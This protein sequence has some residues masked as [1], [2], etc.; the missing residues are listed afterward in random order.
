M[1][2]NPKCGGCH[3][4]RKATKTS[5]APQSLVRPHSLVPPTAAYTNSCHP[6]QRTQTW[7]S[8]VNAR[9]HIHHM[10]AYTMLYMH[11]STRTPEREG[12]GGGG[13]PPDPPPPPK[14]N[15]VPLGSGR[16]Y[17]PAPRQVGLPLTLYCLQTPIPACR[18]AWAIGAMRAGRIF[19]QRPHVLVPVV[20]RSP[21]TAYVA[22]YSSAAVD[23]R[24]AFLRP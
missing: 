12:G 23:R 6:L 8:M 2:R 17:N 24:G 7:C 13:G 15:A 14:K 4:R 22:V 20:T 9:G 3:R 19:T 18:F 11:V 21:T 10:H 1:S 16:S 5:T